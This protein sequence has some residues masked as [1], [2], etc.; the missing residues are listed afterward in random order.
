MKHFLLALALAGIGHAAYAQN[1]SP[2]V[3]LV[4]LGQSI[5]LNDPRGVMDAPL[6]SL[7]PMMRNADVVFT[8][9]EGAVKGAGCVCKPMREG[10]FQHASPPDVFDFL[11]FAHVNLL[12]LANNHSWDL[13]TDGVVSTRDEALRRGMVVAGSGHNIDEALAPGVITVNGIRIAL[14]AMATVKISDSAMATSTLPGV[15]LLR[16]DNT[17]DWNRNI[18]AIKAAKK[19]ADVVIVY[20]HFQTVGTP[21]WQR[22]WAHAAIDAGGTIYVAHGEPQLFGVESYDGKPILYGLGNFI[23]QT[24]TE[25]G[26]YPQEVWEAAIAELTVGKGTVS[27]VRLTPILVKDAPSLATR[28]FPVVAVDSVRDRILDRLAKL[29]REL[30]T[31]LKLDNGTA[32]LASSH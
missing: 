6:G 14:V 10:V 30:G 11:R 4:L 8:N 7:L 16:I 32:S 13:G 27:S 17:A 31:N 21:E 2:S 28:G 22:R 29:S 20:Q 3:K 15:N 24:K 19:N 18:A 9:F 1:D 23:F 12:S 26:H 25:P 5:I